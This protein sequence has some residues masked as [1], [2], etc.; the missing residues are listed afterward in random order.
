MS[1]SWGSNSILTFVQIA[2]GSD[3]ESIN[4]K[5]T[6]VVLEHNPETNY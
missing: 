3:I 2:E 1:D 4:K 5:L 6:D